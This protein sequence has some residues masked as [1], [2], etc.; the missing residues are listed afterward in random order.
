MM[1]ELTAFLFG[2]WIVVLSSLLFHAYLLGIRNSKSCLHGLI[3]FRRLVFPKVLTCT[4]QKH[5]ARYSFHTL[6]NWQPGRYLTS[7]Y[8]LGAM[9]VY[10]EMRL[11]PIMSL[12]VVGS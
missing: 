12:A 11:Y 9:V 8:E 10:T 7:F 1:G 2:I 4:T 3:A 6:T 5:F